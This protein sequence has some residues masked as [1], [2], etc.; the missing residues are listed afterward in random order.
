MMLRHRDSPTAWKRLKTIMLYKKGDP[1]SPRAW[2]P[3]TLSSTL[4]RITMCHIARV[5]QTVN[6]SR[7]FISPQQKG[8]VRTP[9]GIIEHT[10]V[11]QELTS[12]A[13]RV[14]KSLYYTFIDL[15]D[16]FGSVPHTLISGA[17]T[18][19]GLPPA[20]R[21]AILAGYHDSFTNIHIHQ[22]VSN[23]LPFNCGVKQGCSLS[24]TLFNLSIE[25]L[26][27]ALARSEDGYKI[28]D[29]VVS[30]QAY[31]DDLVIISDT[32]V[33]MQ[34]LLDTVTRFCELTKIVIEVSKCSSICYGY[35]GHQRTIPS[36]PFVL[37]GR[38]VP[39][40]N[41]MSASDYLGVWIGARSNACKKHIMRRIESVHSDCVK[42]S[43]SPLKLTQKIDAVRRFLLPKLE[44]EFLAGICPAKRLST[45]DKNIRFL[46]SKAIGAQGLPTELF[47]LKWT[48]GGL[49]LQE[50]WVREKVLTINAFLHLFET[51]SSSTSR[52]FRHCCNQEIAHRRLET[53]AESPTLGI[54]WS[55]SISGTSSLFTRT[56]HALQKLELGL[57][58]VNNAWL[59]T[60]L[61]TAEPFEITPD[62]LLKTIN[63]VL[64]SRYCKC[65]DRKPFK[66]H[67]F[68]SVRDSKVSNFWL[69]HESPTSDNIVRFALR[70]R[71][72]S[73]LTGEAAHLKDQNNPGRCPI[74]QQNESLMHI[75]NGCRPRRHC[76]VA[77]HNAVAREVVSLLQSQD[78]FNSVIHLDSTVKGPRDERLVGE[79]AER[80]FRP[81]LWWWQNGT[82]N[83]LE[84][85]VPYATLKDPQEADQEQ[86]RECSLETRRKQKEEKYR[87][88]VEECTRQFGTPTVLHIVVVSSL[89]A[90]PKATLRTLTKLVTDEKKAILT[91]KRIAVA[92]LRE[93]MSVYFNYENTAVPPRNVDNT[94]HQDD[95]D[96]SVEGPLPEASPAS[97]DELD[98]RVPHWADDRFRDLFRDAYDV[99]TGPEDYHTDHDRSDSGSERLDQ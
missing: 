87:P 21:D 33:G 15:R 79:I 88:L 13:C 5:L 23:D 85:T 69:H 11:L 96:D 74:C 42:V 50:L 78:G 71:T 98:H 52:L 12:D 58:K 93:S 70:A 18:S 64:Q 57:R 89:G 56:V 95:S 47:Y 43:G 16:A 32:E 77:R 72:N 17:M 38:Q 19:V 9:S 44:Y 73:F 34:R 35:D 51:T 92:A 82:L 68:Y 81:D 31:A 4:Y 8:F 83:L 91:A 75:L 84:I 22:H 28:D 80:R 99:L 46:L 65:I 3:I 20:L 30:V 14:K 94:I 67:S 1:D 55:N 27:Q 62:T 76:F 24:P 66:G 63:G 48:N 10:Q 97:D 90:V 6:S 25:G 2:R 61:A 60:D 37:A 53:D 36:V 41:L 29:Q 7:R 49:G 26:I 45:L 40:I 54:T 39:S 59:L 86:E